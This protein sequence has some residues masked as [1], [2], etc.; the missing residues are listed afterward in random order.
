[1]NGTQPFPSESPRAGEASDAVASALLRLGSLQA[2]RGVAVPARG[3]GTCEQNHPSL[4]GVLGFRALGL[5]GFR[6]LGL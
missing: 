6:A 3:G 5:Q 2:P 1:M 4:L